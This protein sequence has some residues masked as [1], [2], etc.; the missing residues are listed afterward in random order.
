M[1]YT[2][3]V[4]LLNKGLAAGLS[5][6]DVF[7]LQRAFSGFGNKTTTGSAHAWAS[8]AGALGPSPT[9]MVTT[10]A[11][12]SSYCAFDAT[13]DRC[14][15]DCKCRRSCQSFSGCVGV[16]CLRCAVKYP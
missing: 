6:T 16:Y 8:T 14:R 4:C 1:F 9:P 13:D 12:C 10:G 2:F 3:N 11:G 5:S 15:D 7:A